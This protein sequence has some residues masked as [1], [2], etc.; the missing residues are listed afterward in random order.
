MSNRALT[1]ALSITAAIG[2]VAIAVSAAQRRVCSAES[3]SER[4]R[5]FRPKALFGSSEMMIGFGQ[6]TTPARL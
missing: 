2:A 4:F 3:T 6:A 1:I 5:M